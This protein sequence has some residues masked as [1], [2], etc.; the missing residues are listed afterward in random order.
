ML[1]DNDILI[2][3]SLLKIGKRI[4]S[5]YE[6]I[7]QSD[8]IH[9]YCFIISRLIDSEEKLISNLN[10]DDI[11]LERIEEYIQE[12]AGLYLDSNLPVSTIIYLDKTNY[13]FFRVLA[14]CRYYNSV[15]K[16]PSLDL[17]FFRPKI[18]DIECALHY[19]ITKR[20][21]E[22]LESKKLKER[23]FRHSLYILVDSPLVEKY[24]ME[25][26]LSLNTMPNSLDL[27]IDAYA[28]KNPTT[29]SFLIR[30]T[31]IYE[32]IINKRIKEILSQLLEL[33]RDEASLI[34]SAYKTSDVFLNLISYLK[35]LIAISGTEERMDIYNKIYSII[36]GENREDSYYLKILLKDLIIEVEEYLVPKRESTSLINRR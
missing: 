25:T 18:Q 2:I 6:S 24:C 15:I 16:N 17:E 28:Y 10:L 19:S 34:G 3:E 5:L 35:A 36:N 33:I 8:D 30:R 21:I 7:L 27:Y 1:D 4:S 32:I 9:K 26:N 23:A 22:K 31:K 12:K 29:D 14:R 20:K 13:S 11:K